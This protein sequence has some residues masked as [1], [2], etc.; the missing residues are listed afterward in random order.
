MI[1][2]ANDLLLH[3]Q[4]AVE[5][6]FELCSACVCVPFVFTKDGQ[7]RRKN[8]TLSH[9]RVKI[10]SL[11]ERNTCTKIKPQK[12]EEINKNK[13]EKK[14]EGSWEATATCL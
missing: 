13:K 7:K 5:I 8:I 11:A 4:N 12:K 10:G 3:S 1:A 14:E 2:Y 9:K 6:W